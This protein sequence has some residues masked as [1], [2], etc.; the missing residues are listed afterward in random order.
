MGNSAGLGKSKSLVVIA[1]DIGTTR[2]GYAI[3]V[4]NHGN[5][6]TLPTYGQMLEKDRVPTILL[7]KSDKTFHSFGYE[8]Q[9]KYAEMKEN[10]RKSHVYM[11]RIKMRLFS[12]QKVDREICDQFAFIIKHI[13]D[14]A[15]E[16]AQ[17]LVGNLKEEHVRWVLTIPSI[18]TDCARRLMTEAAN[19]AGIVK[20][21]LVLEPEAASLF[22][23]GNALIDR[24]DSVEKL[25][26]GHKYILADL[27]GGTADFVVH[28]ILKDGGFRQLYKASGGDFGGDTVN[29]QY[30]EFLESLFSASVL[31]NFKQSYADLHFEMMDDFEEKK[32]QF[33]KYGDNRG[34][35]LAIQSALL[36][37]FEN[38]KRTLKQVT[39]EPIFSPIVSFDQ[40]SER[41]EISYKQMEKFFEKSVYGI[42]EHLKA[43]IADCKDI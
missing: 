6:V 28:E 25:P 42:I 23:S 3:S 15:M 31:N 30:M 43:I 9:R 20:T 19:K 26:V 12:I 13:K 1:I 36:K 11:E 2:T 18:W 41:L 17:L 33:G 27:G 34:T 24:N 14:L 37:R 10:D 22:C 8:A 16:A 5:G 38:N 35:K 4:G 32:R 21:K 29:I 7:L 40:Q 39:L